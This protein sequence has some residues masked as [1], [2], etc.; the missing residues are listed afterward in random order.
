MYA[1]SEVVALL[2]EPALESSKEW[3]GQALYGRRGG[4]SENQTAA[5]VINT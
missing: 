5:Y 2:N 1:I 3:A 4:E